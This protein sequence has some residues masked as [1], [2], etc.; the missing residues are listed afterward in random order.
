M[1]RDLNEMREAIV[2]S[3]ERGTAGVEEA[4]TCL[5]SSGNSSK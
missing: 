4:G 2:L 3:R 5:V 1:N